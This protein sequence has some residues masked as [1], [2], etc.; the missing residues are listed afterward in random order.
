MTLDTESTWDVTP[1]GEDHTLRLWSALTVRR[2]I[3]HSDQQ[4]YQW[5]RGETAAELVAEIERRVVGLDTLWVCC[6]NLSFDLGLTRL[7][8]LLSE[9]GWQPQVQSLSPG[10]PWMR[11]GRGTKRVT[12][13]DSFT[14]LPVSLA[15]LGE[16][17]GVAKPD[18]P[19]SDDSPAAWRA[20]CDADVEI[21]ATAMLE[22]MA[23]WDAEKLGH[24]SVTG[25]ASGWNALRHRDDL[26]AILIDPDPDR[27]AFERS[28]IYGGRREAYHVGKLSG[29]IYRDED[30][31]GAYPGVARDHPL[32]FRCAGH[33]PQM[34]A[35][36]FAK[37][38]GNLGVI[39]HCTVRDARG[40]VPVRVGGEVFF[41]T[42]DVATTLASPEIRR[43][44]ELGVQVDIGPG[45]LYWLSK[46]YGGWARWVMAL[47][48]G[49]LEG[50][51]AVARVT[52]KHWSRAVIGKFAQHVSSV[53]RIGPSQFS[54]WH[55]ERGWDADAKTDFQVVH[56][57][58]EM[59]HVD[60]DQESENAF[61]AVLA[62]VESYVRCQVDI[63]VREM[64]GGN[65]LQVDTDGCLLEQ[66]GR[67]DSADWARAR[68]GIDLRCKSVVSSVEILG[69]QHLWIGGESRL[70][71]VPRGAA[72]V[73]E[74]TYVGRIW[75]GLTWQLSQAGSEGYR[76]PLAS[77]RIVGP[78]THRWVFVDGSTRAVACHIESGVTVI[79][80]PTA[81]TLG[82]PVSDL[83]RVQ[84]PLLQPL[85]PE[86]PRLKVAPASAD[87]TTERV[88]RAKRGVNDA[89]GLPDPHSG[90]RLA[91]SSEGAP[92]GQLVGSLCEMER[93]CGIM[94][95]VIAEPGAGR[96]PCDRAT[97][98]R[99]PP[100][101]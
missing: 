89:E 64:P 7:P 93:L 55:V 40:H 100:G 92:L 95:K 78:Y 39:A 84:H 99:S 18:L 10:A 20:R 59:Y 41:P 54:G 83:A 58:G 52:G 24:W 85:L 28:A 4:T 48:D 33:F 82:R 68:L 45:Y 72:R 21:L 17:V 32:P 1:L 51:P 16:M 6:H 80:S 81:E 65:V 35:A 63:M 86:L 15:V 9:R 25:P 37:L 5:G 3:P 60:P 67:N 98:S 27:R 26:P 74:D 91:Q 29:G 87:G 71:G 43:L 101:T 76:R 23:W 56:M 75:P 62:F 22:L 73:T 31:H 90:L 69:P 14:W 97:A 11:L 44:V 2:R 53:E 30:I 50:A 38:P 36:K 70:S 96:R 57:A 19:D 46:G 13:I 66:T 42:G 34:G 12:F 47:A 8:Q 61:P 88:P 77:V 49:Q 79:E 94:H